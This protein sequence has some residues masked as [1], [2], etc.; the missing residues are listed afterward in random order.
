MALK[1]RLYMYFDALMQISISLNASD[2]LAGTKEL[3]LKITLGKRNRAEA[4]RGRNPTVRPNLI[5]QK[6]SKFSRNAYFAIEK[7]EKALKMDTR[8]PGMVVRSLWVREDHDRGP[9]KQLSSAQSSVFFALGTVTAIYLTKPGGKLRPF[10]KK[11]DAGTASE[12][13]L[14]WDSLWALY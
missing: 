4:Q 5:S 11:D 14:I 6:V 12:F 7:D 3:D 9:R 2:E 10:R 13:R 1:C 8:D